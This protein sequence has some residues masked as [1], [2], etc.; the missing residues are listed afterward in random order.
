[1]KPLKISGWYFLIVFS[2]AAF[3][4]TMPNEWRFHP[5][6]SRPTRLRNAYTDPSVSPPIILLGDCQ[7]RNCPW[8]FYR[9]SDSGAALKGR[10]FPPIRG[11][12]Q[13]PVKVA[14]VLTGMHQIAHEAPP[15]EIEKMLKDGEKEILE[16]WPDA[17]VI[18]V[19]PQEVYEIAK[20]EGRGDRGI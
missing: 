15:E 1:M 19:P 8:P 5:K 17:K 18:I 4:W 10:A 2:V 16:T 12:W 20:V 13:R 6:L 7:A 11:L 3:V 14:I 9:V